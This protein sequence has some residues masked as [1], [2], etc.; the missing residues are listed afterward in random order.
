MTPQSPQAIKK[1]NLEQA[2]YILDMLSDKVL[3][4]WVPGNNPVIAMDRFGKIWFQSEMETSEEETII[5][6]HADDL[7]K[8]GEGWNDATPLD[9]LEFLFQD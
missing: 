8:W 6:E 4:S 5:M 3:F 1:H 7:S 2:Q 9:V